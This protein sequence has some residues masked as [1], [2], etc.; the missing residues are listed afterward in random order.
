MKKIVQASIFKYVFEF[1]MRLLIFRLFK[2]TV[3]KGLF[4]HPLFGSVV[5]WKIG[6]RLLVLL[7]YFLDNFL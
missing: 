7:K 1:A 5:F 3:V 6:G 4:E 2:F